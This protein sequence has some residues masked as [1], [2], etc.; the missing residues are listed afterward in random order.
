MA[1]GIVWLD[2]DRIKDIVREEV[3][4]VFP[5]NDT[6]TKTDTIK[7]YVERDRRNESSKPAPDYT[8]DT[9]TLS[10]ADSLAIDSLNLFVKKDELLYTKNIKLIQISGGK[11]ALDTAM[12]KAADVDPQGLPTVFQVE[13]WKSPIN[14]KGYKLGKG[15][16]VL[17]GIYHSD[18]IS[19]LA[20]GNSLFLKNRNY[21]FAL[22]PTEEFYG[23]SP[24]TDK[25]LLAQLNQ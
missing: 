2:F 10:A 18:D 9:D 24:V 11:G 14:Y 15:K 22:E 12:A 23:F 5:K 1:F 19:L 25:N 20:I 21:F 8:I 4:K 6:A 16:I 13:F 17:F 3:Q 7:V